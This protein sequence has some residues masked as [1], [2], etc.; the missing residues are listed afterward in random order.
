MVSLAVAAVTL[1]TMVGLNVWGTKNLRLYAVLIGLALGYGLSLV[2]GVL[3]ASQFA[4]V[5][6][7]PW[8]GAPVLDSMLQIDF[9]WSLVPV[10]AIVSICG[11][12][13]SFGNL[14]LCEKINDE[15][16]HEPN[17]RRI[18][19][20]LMADA[21]AVTLS[22]LLG[23][24]ASDT[25]SSNV[26]LSAASG[27]TS[28]WIAFGAGALFITLAF[29]P[30]LGALLSVMPDPVAGAILVFVTCFMLVSG[31]QI[32]LSAK[33]DT[34]RIFVV[35]IALCFGFSLDILP[36]LYVHVAPW[37]RPLFDSSLTLATVIA[38]VLNQIV[39]IGEPKPAPEKAPEV[40]SVKA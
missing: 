13:K 14:V 3:P 25:S 18:G 36:A 6:A 33:L 17:A 11:A 40:E 9:R 23:G 5:G 27:A 39:R 34:R 38:V 29:S 22:G 12:L 2:T 37:L 7:A 16:W 8:V 21:F 10:F 15:D 31:L 28:R 20:G 4:A 19:N 24:M 1:A 32:I 35:G 26:A 30:K